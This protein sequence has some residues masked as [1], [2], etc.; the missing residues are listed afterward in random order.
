MAESVH[1]STYFDEKLI[2]EVHKYPTLY[3][4]KRQDYKDADTKRNIWV[5]IANDLKSDA[6]TCETR[7]LHKFGKKD[8]Q[9]FTIS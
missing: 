7:F 1:D 4:T 3:D 9:Y 8:I 6:K 5:A 2:G